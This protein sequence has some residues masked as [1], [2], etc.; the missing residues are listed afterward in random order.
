MHRVIVSVWLAAAVAAA[1]AQGLVG[2]D[3]KT[4]SVKVGKA[5]DLALVDGDPS[6]R[7]G[8]LRQTRIVMLDGKLLDADALRRAAGF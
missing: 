3:A 5:A 7:I 1:L 4:S 6:T 2:Q 8:D